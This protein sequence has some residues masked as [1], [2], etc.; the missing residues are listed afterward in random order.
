MRVPA[1]VGR[2]PAHP[3]VRSTTAQRAKRRAHSLAAWTG[4]AVLLGVAL[5]THNL[6][7]LLQCDGLWT[8]DVNQIQQGNAAAWDWLCGVAEA[9]SVRERVCC[10]AP[11]D[12]HRL[13][14]PPRSQG[15]KHRLVSV[16]E[17]S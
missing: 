1:S 16:T 17:M 15:L 14:H 6:L 10:A 5:N 7:T 3:R 4:W 11:S 9:E 13:V 12:N 8:G 2:A